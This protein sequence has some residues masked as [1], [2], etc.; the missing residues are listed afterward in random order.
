MS[1][2]VHFRPRTLFCT[3]WL[4][5]A[6]LNVSETLYDVSIVFQ[7]SDYVCVLDNPQNNEQNYVQAFYYV[8]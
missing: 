4:G 7:E 5:F 8:A 2:G 1:C 3:V 6:F